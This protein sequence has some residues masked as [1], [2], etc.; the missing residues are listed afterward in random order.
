MDIIGFLKKYALQVAAVLVVALVVSVVW[1]MFFSSHAKAIA[2]LNE[3]IE[4]RDERLEEY[5]A[6]FEAL[7]AREEQLAQ[8]IE[9]LQGQ[10]QTVVASV[11]AGD[12][13]IQEIKDEAIELGEALE[14]IKENT[15]S[16]ASRSRGLLARPDDRSN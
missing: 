5:E 13:T 15:R 6:E 10:L 14:I 16:A 1:E 2:L 12:A 4:A 7:A 8:D 9:K 11:E 3:Q